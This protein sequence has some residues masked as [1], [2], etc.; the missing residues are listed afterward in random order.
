MRKHLCWIAVVV[1]SGCKRADLPDD[2]QVLCASDADCLNGFVCAVDAAAPTCIRAEQFGEI[3]GDG[4]LGGDEAC[5]A[6]KANADAPDAPCRLDCTLPRCGDGIVDGDAGEAC[7]DDVGCRTDCR[8]CGDGVVQLEFEA[9][10]DGID[11]LLGN[12]DG[13]P[14]TASCA[15]ARCGD[16]HVQIDIEGCDDGDTVDDNACTNAC[17]LPTCGDAIVQPGEDC[18]DGNQSNVDACTN[19]CKLPTCGDAFVQ[20]GEDCD[21]GVD[22]DD[23][24]PC[25]D[26][27]QDNVCG[28]GLHLDNGDEDCDDGNDDDDDD[29]SNACTLP[30]CGDGITQLGVSEGCDDGNLVDTDACTNDCQSARC[31]D[32]IIQLGEDCDDGDGANGDDELCTLACAL[33][34]CGDNKVLTGVEDC[35]DGDDVNDNACSNACT[36]PRCGDGIEQASGAEQCDDGNQVDEDTCTNKCL[37]PRCGDRILQLGAGE[38]CDEGDDANSD[39]SPCTSLCRLNICGDGKVLEGVEA[40]DD[41]NRASGDGCKGDCAKIELCGDGVVDSGEECDDGNLN[42]SDTCG[43]CRLV[44]W[45]ISVPTGFGPSGGA[46]GRTAIENPRALAVDQVGHVVIASSSQVFRITNGQ[47]TAIAGTDDVNQNPSSVRDGVPATGV[48]IGRDVNGVGVDGFGRVLIA[49]TNVNHILR[50]EANGTLRIVAGNGNQQGAG[51]GDPQDDDGPALEVAIGRPE[52]AIVDV[53]GRIVFADPLSRRVR[54]V[55][56]EG[57]IETIAGP[58]GLSNPCGLA[59]DEDGRILVL[60]RSGAGALQRIEDD[61]SLTLLGGASS[62]FSGDEGPAVDAEF[63]APEGIAVDLVTGTI[64]IADSSNNRIR[65]I[66]PGLDATRVVRTIA[67]GGAI[68]KAPDGTAAL[69][70]TLVA[71]QAV[72]FV[73]GHVIFSDRNS[74]VR[75]IEDDGTLST[76]AGTGADAVDGGG[77][78]A[79]SVASA[80][81]SVAIDALGRV[82]F[83]EGDFGSGGR[84]RRLEPNGTLTNLAGTGIPGVTGDGGPATAAQIQQPFGLAVDDDGNV[85]F[86]EFNASVVRRIDAVDG[87]ISTVA[88][89][90]TPGTAGADGV[91]ATAAQLD[92]PHSLAIDSTGRLIIGDASARVRRVEL[93][94]TIKTIAGTGVSGLLGDGLQATAAQIQGDGIAVDGSDRLLIAEF[95]GGRVRRVNGDG[96][97]VTVAGNGQGTGGDNGL[98]I[99]AQLTNPKALAAGVGDEFFIGEFGRGTVRRVDGAGII[100]LF[101]GGA[102]APLGDLGDGGPA[103][104]ASTQVFAGMVL[105][106]VGRLV[107]ANSGADARLRRIELDGTITTIAGGLHPFGGPFAVAAVPTPAAL[108][109]MDGDLLATSQSA[110][111]ILRLDFDGAGSVDVVA[112]RDGGF[113]LG[114]DPTGPNQ[115]LFFRALE[116]ASGVAFDG[117]QTLFVSE[118]AAGTILQIAMIDRADAATWTVSLLGGAEGVNTHA[119]GPLASARFIRPAGLA[120][121][122]AGDRL[123]VVDAGGHRLRVIDLAAANVDTVVGSGAP[124]DGDG[125]LNGPEAVAVNAS[126]AVYVADTGNHRV[127]RVD[128]GTTSTVLG[129]GEAASAGDGFPSPSFPVE[130]P[131]GL[132]FDSF[133]NLLVTSTRTVRLVT[134]DDLGGVDGKSGVVTLYG[135]S[136]R[137]AFP[138]DS[139]FCLSGVAERAEGVIDVVDACQGFVVELRRFP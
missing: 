96:T 98:A 31:G 56:D 43:G 134:A 69:A 124:G 108:T 22:N 111:R 9:C 127:V 117:D 73:D 76:V 132:A 16:G 12:R 123:F 83:S 122:V 42:P 24:A 40:C 33:N 80:P 107:I 28:D 84:V 34:E 85:F 91:A 113:G 64:F 114:G 65:R 131:R 57:G 116:G 37:D 47:M 97:I 39:A 119:D 71:P 125:Q 26:D 126:G 121:D 128:D 62:G 136:P 11:V 52:A 87:T 129:T 75:R 92:S 29:C 106:S 59:L 74:R 19:V 50:V 25:T 109:L 46:P 27:C 7:D 1:V 103:T 32:A 104:A 79:L 105:D 10:D 78:S 35:D 137:N 120:Y 93:D 17:A 63:N 81:N 4:V 48:P 21:E 15:A 58:G 36:A 68:A 55:T 90:G 139:T 77:N 67:G 51:G 110:G 101:A 14:C 86:G 41:G 3:C 5:D 8:A 133:G 82:L 112:G 95:L 135:A 53:Q 88:G 23:Q 13:G 61:G 115:S 70:A 94:G 49:A 72:A 138:A 100:S 99:N 6:G 102:A 18:D 20:L 45:G 30:R 118:G 89:T 66:D 38:Q 44:S 60:S 54:R 2:V 130:S